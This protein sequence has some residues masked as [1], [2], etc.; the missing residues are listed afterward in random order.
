MQNENIKIIYDEDGEDLER[1]ILEVFKEYLEA[2]NL[3]N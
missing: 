1:K 3:D 2:K